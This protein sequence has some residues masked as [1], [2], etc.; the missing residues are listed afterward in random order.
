M[1][2]TMNQRVVTSTTTPLPQHIHAHTF[3]DSLMMR[4]GQTD[5]DTTCDT[6]SMHHVFRHNRPEIPNSGAEHG[7]DAW[8]LAAKEDVLA[9]EQTGSPDAKG[10]LCHESGARS[11][12]GDG[13]VATES[14][15]E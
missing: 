4:Q 15:Y 1:A 12:G 14:G 8:Y 13:Q 7:V 11:Q 5:A 3:D 6:N 10:Q 2:T 9:L